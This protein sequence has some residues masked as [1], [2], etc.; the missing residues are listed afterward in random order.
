MQNVRV[1]A[2]TSSVRRADV[3][4]KEHGVPHQLQDAAASRRMLSSL[5]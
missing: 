5:R 1:P 2:G 3:P 4:S